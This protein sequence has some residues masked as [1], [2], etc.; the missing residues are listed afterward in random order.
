MLNVTGRVTQLKLNHVFK[1]FN[2]T[3]PD[4]L[5]QFFTRTRSIHSIS[6]RNSAENFHIPYAK[7]L[8]FHSFYYTAIKD[9]NALPANVKL[10]NS[11]SHFK[12]ACK[13]FMATRA[14]SSEN[15]DMNYY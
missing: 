11:I 13:K 6:T 15:D 12:T 5:G 4:Y 3:A 14:T 7:G 8:V 10:S 9:W 2:G 1:I